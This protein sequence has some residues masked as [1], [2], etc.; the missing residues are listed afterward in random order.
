ML[1][2]LLRFL[3]FSFPSFDLRIGAEWWIQHFGN[4]FSLP[5]RVPFISC[6]NYEFLGSMPW[7]IVLFSLNLEFF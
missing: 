2:I 5:S 1:P 6:E 3:R 7:M 4:S